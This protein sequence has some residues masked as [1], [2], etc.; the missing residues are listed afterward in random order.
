M[1]I[2]FKGDI[3]C[4]IFNIKFLGC[5]IGNCIDFGMVLICGLMLVLF[6]YLFIVYQ[7][8]IYVWV[9]VCCV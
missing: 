1:V 2:G 5:S 8:I 3:S 7:Y 9:W 6:Y 4:C